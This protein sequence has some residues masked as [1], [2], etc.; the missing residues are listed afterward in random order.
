M[1]GALSDLLLARAAR[2]GVEQQ[3]VGVEAM[4][5]ARRVRPMHAVAVELARGEARHIAVP[6]LVG[7][8]RQ[9]DARRLGAARVKQAKLH[10]RRMSGEQGEVYAAPVIG[11]AKRPRRPGI[12]LQLH[13]RQSSSPSAGLSRGSTSSSAARKGI[14]KN[15]GR[16]SPSYTISWN[17]LSARNNGSSSPPA[18][19]DPL[20][21]SSRAM[22]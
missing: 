3:L 6:H 17:S 5:V 9:R 7:V 18:R 21:E 2:I 1:N 15:T 8:L 22:P 11:R 20:K 19:C 12:E 16:C 13:C 4:A 14:G 10:A